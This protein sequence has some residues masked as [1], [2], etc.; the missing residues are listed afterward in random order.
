MAAGSWQV[1]LSA[2]GEA[3]EGSLSVPVPALPQ[4]TRGMQLGLG[5]LLAALGLLLASAV[6]SIIGAIVRDAPL[7]PG[8][9]ADARRERLARRA[10]AITAVGIAL[11]LWGGRAWW[12]AEADDYAKYVYKPIALD[13][14]AGGNTLS[15]SL[16]DPGWLR[17]RRL[18]DWVPD[19]GHLMH[20]FMVRVPELDRVWHLH[21]DEAGPARFT[22]KLPAVPKGRYALYADVVHQT[23]LAET[24]TVEIELPEIAG[25]PLT[26]DDATGPSD[27][28]GGLQ[29]SDDRPMRARQVGRLSFRVLDPKDLE[30][31]MGMAGHAAVVRRDRSVFA[32]LHPTG[33]VPMAAI[34]VATGDPHAG[35]AQGAVPAEISFP[36][37]FP[38]AGDY[39]VFVQIKRAG[40]VQ[41][42]VFDYTVTD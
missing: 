40:V 11:I 4:R 8:E 26:G 3:G 21:P 41:T 39:R 6:V 31:Y 20:L 7:D 9:V 42:G 22:Q 17:G 13:A 12:G 34:A 29:R 24:A 16:V 33:S 19:H 23:G 25:T 10:M 18:D 37:A 15:L 35:H 38:R 27:N 1:K 2:A 28:N 32:H 30:L 5:L 36:Y 14:K